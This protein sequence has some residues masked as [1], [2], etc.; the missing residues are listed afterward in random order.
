MLEASK[1]LFVSNAKLIAL[2]K[3]L[4]ERKAAMKDAGTLKNARYDIVCLCVCG[5]G[6]GGGGGV[7][8]GVEGTH[9]NVSFIAL[10]WS[11]AKP[12]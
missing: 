8:A 6:G 10:N 2:M 12:C 5:G 7:V 11:H 9:A 1:G 4:Q 3:D